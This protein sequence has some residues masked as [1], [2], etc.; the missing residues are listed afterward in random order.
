MKFQKEMHNIWLKLKS[1][2]I[3]EDKNQ[4]QEKKGINTIP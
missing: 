2:N 4:L 3:L 1:K